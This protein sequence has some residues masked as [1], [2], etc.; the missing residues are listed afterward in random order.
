MSKVVE[1]P[2]TGI[3]DGRSPKTSRGKKLIQGRLSF[4]SIDN[5]TAVPKVKNCKTFEVSGEA[6]GLDEVVVVDN[7]SPSVE[8]IE[9]DDTSKYHSL[10]EDSDDSNSIPNVSLAEGE[11]DS[12]L[13][14]SHVS[15]DEL[16]KSSSSANASTPRQA[17]LQKKKLERLKEK[18]IKE[19]MKLAPTVRSEF[20]SSR[21]DFLDQIL[22]KPKP[23]TEV[24]R[25]QYKGNRGRNYGATWPLIKDSE[26]EVIDEDEAE[27]TMNKEDIITVVP[28]LPRRMR[29]K[30]LKFCE[31]RRPAYWG[32]WGKTSHLV[33]PRRPFG[34]ENIFDYDVDSDDEWEEEVEPGESLT[35]SEAEGEEKEPADDYEVDNEFLVPHGYLSD[36]E[37]E[38]DDDE[39]PMSPSEAKEKLKL[40]EEQ[41]E[42]ELKQKTCHIK[43]SLIGCCWTD[44][45]NHEPQLLKVLQRYATVVFSSATPIRL[46]CSELL[47]EN[48]E[49][50]VADET[51]R[52]ENKASKRLVS[53]NDIPALVRL[54]HGSSYSKLTIV[55][56]FQSYLERN[57]TDENK[58]APSKAQILAKIAEIA[59]WTK[60]TE[61]GT[62]NGRTCWL[63]QPDVLGHYDLKEL[64]VINAWEFATETKKRG[65]KAD[66]SRTE[67]DTPP[68]KTPRVSLIKQFAQPNNF[69]LTKRVTTS[70]EKDLPEL[71]KDTN[72]SGNKSSIVSTPKTK[73]RITLISIPTSGTKKPKTESKSTPLTNFLK[74]MSTKE[75]L[76]KSSNAVEDTEMDEIECLTME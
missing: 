42:R 47:C 74:K 9:I 6:K 10:H 18:E 52:S 60:C 29:P 20:D 4:T 13:D 34:K 73:K 15:N 48:G 45:S 41:F 57:R 61:T 76:S 19:N 23:T 50:P 8:T 40:K 37:G 30:L 70:S 26:V 72:E 27:G 11:L 32:T 67:E 46:S 54:L 53:E 12:E 44:D 22:E 1:I 36:E 64:S 28:A 14:T 59:S 43:P 66:D 2:E 56:E 5:K 63:V 35:D 39:R 31:N 25:L 65:R 55:K 33:G 51:A 58:N 17:E 49:S 21:R 62:M 3:N 16:G 38:K 68:A 24:N 71:G 75:A 7:N 69:L